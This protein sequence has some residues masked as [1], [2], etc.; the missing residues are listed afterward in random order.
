M[1]Q[2]NTILPANM[3]LAVSSRLGMEGPIPGLF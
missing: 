2:V 3:E 1:Y